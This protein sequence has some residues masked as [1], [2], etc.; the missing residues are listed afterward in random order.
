MWALLG[1]DVIKLVVSPPLDRRDFLRQSSAVL[2][3]AGLGVPSAVRA[4]GSPRV[5]SYR[6]LGRTGLEVS[7][8]SFGASR[9]RGDE[10]LVHDAL[11]RGINYFDS[12][13]GYTGGQSEETLGR[14]LKGKR[15]NVYLTSKVQCGTST[16]AG[17]LMLALEASLKR[18]QTD[19]VEI[20]FNHAVNDVDRLKNPEWD[21]FTARAKQQGKIRFTGMSGHG[22]H[23]VECV[24]YA[25]AHDQVDVMLLAYNFGQD[26]AFY[27]Q[28]LGRFDF[29]AIQPGLP[30]A[31]KRA[32]KRDVGVVAMKT[33]MGGRLNDLRPYEHGDATFSQAAFRWVL[34]NPD[35][36]TLIVSMTSHEL[37]AE[38]LGASGATQTSRRDLGLLGRY[39]FK[40]GPSHCFQGCNHCADACP[41]GVPIAEVLRTRMYD[42]D[43]GD[44][45]LAR[46][47][48]AALGDGAAACGS[49][50]GAP[51]LGACPVGLEISAL[52]RDTHQRLR[53][54]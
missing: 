8:I 28:F 51:C 31:L 16:K 10:S 54:G 1:P 18:L 7:D 26:P 50:S 29:V 19:R 22:A 9:L 52:T 42:L 34:S 47:D 25:L 3:A 20:Y 24:D 14:A 39:A 53:I 2:A 46:G 15:E 5:K 43:Y 6:R 11:E 33:L 17:D 38:Y 36:A 35:V 45:Q 48:Y 12:A 21:E 44:P 49:C 32:R 30:E 41:A 37:I 4:E 40:N 27:Q 13:E 23:L